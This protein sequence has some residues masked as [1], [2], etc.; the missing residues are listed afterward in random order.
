MITKWILCEEHKAAACL[1]Y[2]LCFGAGSVRVSADVRIF[3][4]FCDVTR[5]VK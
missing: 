1:P 2:V 5:D 4:S 3:D